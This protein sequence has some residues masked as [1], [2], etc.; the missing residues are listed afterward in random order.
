MCMSA[1]RQMWTDK[2]KK[3][4]NKA[5]NDAVINYLYMV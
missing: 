2:K 4:K 3:K 5:T 1:E